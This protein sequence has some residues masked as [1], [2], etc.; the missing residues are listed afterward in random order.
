MNE[1]ELK[2]AIALE[3]VLLDQVLAAEGEISTEF[4][5][6]RENLESRT[7]E[8][9]EFL[10]LLE[11]KKESAKKEAR[12]W[13][14]RAKL[15]DDRINRIEATIKQTMLV[16]GIRK[17]AGK[18]HSYLVYESGESVEW[19]GEMDYEKIPDE[20]CHVKIVRTLNKNLIKE[21]FNKKLAEVLKLTPS[22]ALKR[23]KA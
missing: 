22:F 20:F 10:R 19:V 2:K 11:E 17:I 7:D 14:E 3:G 13:A 15:L 5:L 1:L 4:E 16:A 21:K 12:E 18:K 6:N 9:Y 8:V 23:S